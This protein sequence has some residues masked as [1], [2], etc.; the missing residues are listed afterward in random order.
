MINMIIKKKKDWNTEPCNLNKKLWYSEP[1]YPK[2]KIWYGEPYD[3]NEG[4]YIPC[5]T[6][7][8]IDKKKILEILT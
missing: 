1:V 3:L 8:K 2:I 4:F 5:K 7:K 6:D